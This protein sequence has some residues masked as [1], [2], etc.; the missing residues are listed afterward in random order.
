MLLLLPTQYIPLSRC[1]LHL[2]PL[3]G[4]QNPTLV[5]WRIGHYPRC[6]IID[7]QK[8]EF[9]SF[10]SFIL[11]SRFTQSVHATLP[12]SVYLNSFSA[13]SVLPGPSGVPGRWIKLVGPFLS[14][15]LAMTAGD[16]V[17]RPLGCWSHR[18]AM[19]SR[20]VHELPIMPRRAWSLLFQTLIPNTLCSLGFIHKGIA[21]FKVCLFFEN[22]DREARHVLRYLQGSGIAQGWLAVNLLLDG[23]QHPFRFAR[24]FLTLHKRASLSASAKRFPQSFP[25]GHLPHCSNPHRG[26]G[27]WWHMPFLMA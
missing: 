21:T 2:L 19:P 23:G 6:N 10:S 24:L 5:P 14:L 4:G 12:L 22:T 9:D 13:S 3:V 17:P 11:S 7:A 16:P 20:R 25:L 15:L 26:G 8:R 1:L 27:V 18:E